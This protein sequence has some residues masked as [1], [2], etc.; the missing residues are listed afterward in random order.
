MTET[1][2]SIEVWKEVKDWN[3]KYLIS[4]RGRFKSIGGKYKKMYPDGYITLGT[5]GD[6]G[7]RM[8][9]MRKPG[10]AVHV[11]IHTLVGEHFCVKPVTTEKLFINHLDGNKLNNNDWNLQWCTPGENVRH[12]VETGLFDT[13]G[14]K[15]MHAKLTN[16]K[17][18][19]MR[20]LRFKEGLTHQKIGEM[21]GVC[22]RQAG[23]VIN[24]VNWGWLK[25]A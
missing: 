22:R 23:D 8:V 10:T 9:T 18:L 7:Y 12:A 17:V 15:H 6:V 20:R 3:G 13:K 11:R 24:G 1:L 4:N 14:E 16:E 25:E 19:E 2:V 21:F 5:I